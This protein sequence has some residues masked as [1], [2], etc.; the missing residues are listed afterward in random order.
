MSRFMINA[1]GV[2]VALFFCQSVMA[3]GLP[4]NS[5]EAAPVSSAQSSNSQV[6]KNQSQ[7][8][9]TSNQ[10]VQDENASG[11]GFIAIE[12]DPLI[13][14]VSDIADEG[15]FHRCYGNP[16]TFPGFDFQ[17]SNGI[18]G[19]NGNGPIVGVRPSPVLVRVA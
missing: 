7:T 15:S 16:L 6:K 14:D 19:E 5:N 1:F 13:V 12:D 9:T 4:E 3:G 2:T 11:V 8:S 17:T 18:L 10:D